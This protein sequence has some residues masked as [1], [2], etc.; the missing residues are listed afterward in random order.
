MGV[1]ET[2]TVSCCL[3]Q[4]GLF[5]NIPQPFI[6]CIKIDFIDDINQPVF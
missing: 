2:K 4:E 6:F 3:K 5:Y 1:R